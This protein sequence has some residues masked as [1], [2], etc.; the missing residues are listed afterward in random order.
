MDSQA[1]KPRQEG[2]TKT[3]LPIDRTCCV[4]RTA[5]VS[6]ASRLSPDEELPELPVSMLCKSWLIE[7]DEPALPELVL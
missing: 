4:A 5:P 2:P 6:Y 1:G 7:L 3:P